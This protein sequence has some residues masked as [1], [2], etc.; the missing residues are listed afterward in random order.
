VGLSEQ[1]LAGLSAEHSAESDFSQLERAVI[2]YARQ[3]TRA[4][5]IDDSLYAELR[6]YFSLDQMMELCFTIGIANIVNRFHA[7]FHTPLDEH[8][9]N[10]LARDG[11]PF[12]LPDEP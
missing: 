2:R 4:E 1:Q 11:A 8:T 9:R 3:L 5:P 6:E 10:Q 7:T 12:G